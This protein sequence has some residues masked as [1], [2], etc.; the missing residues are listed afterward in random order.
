MA[1]KNLAWTC[2]GL[3]SGLISVA[4]AQQAD[5]ATLMEVIVTA[6]RVEESLQKA[7]AAITALDDQ[8][9]IDAGVSQSGDLN[10]LMPGLNIGMGGP[11]SQV[12]LRGVGNYGTNGF[13]DPA[14][15]F[16]VDGI[17]LARFS[18][19]NGI[20]FDLERI[21]VLKGPQGTLYGRN[22][23]GGAVN[24]ITRKPSREDAAGIGLEAGNY[25][26]GKING[27]LNGPLG[28]R[29]SARVAFQSTKR[30]GYLSDG[31]NDD[32]SQAV[33]LGLKFD[34]SDSTSLLLSAGLT[35]IG[36]RGQVHVP[37]NRNG[38]FDNSDP[39]IGPSVGAA[40]M[41]R[42]IAPA[43][44]TGPF[45]DWQNRGVSRADGYLDVQ[46]KSVT[47]QLDT[48]LGGNDLTIQANHMKTDNNSKS[49]GPGFMFFPDE[50]DTQMSLEARL[51]GNT[52]SVRWVGGLYGF[53][54]N[55]EFTFWVD[56]GYRFNQTGTDVDQLD[57]KTVA[58]F[59]QATYSFSDTFRVTGGIRFT[60]ESKEISG[61]IFGREALASPPNDVFLPGP[62]P[63]GFELGCPP[64]TTRVLANVVAAAI[65][66][67]ATNTD[68][69]SYIWPY[70]RDIMVG[71]N[72]FDDTSWKLGADWDLNPSSMMYA[73]VSRGFKAGGFFASGNNSDLVGNKFNPET[74]VAYAFGSKN[75]FNGDRVQLNG[76][77]F[78]FDYKD[79][80]ENYLAPSN[81][82]GGFNFVTQTADAEIYGLDLELDVALSAND[83]L[84]AKLQ[85]LHAE[86]TRARFVNASPGPGNPG[87]VS[88][89]PTTQGT[90]P[91]VW[92]NNCTGF[93][94]PRSPKLS[95]TVDYSHT[96][97]LASGAGVVAGVAAQYS[98]AYWA[99][100]DYNPLQRQQSF[101]KWD[102]DLGYHGVDDKWSLTL[103]GANLS[104]EVVFTNAFM[105]PG[106]N[107]T[108]AY[109]SF[110]QL[111]APRT[112]GVR[113]AT[114]F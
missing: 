1:R 89:C 11:S 26:L 97:R 62:P 15:A 113:F 83:K 92:Y 47:A 52:G 13:A 32:E 81:S 105:Y 111:A 95:G 63:G 103:W 2:I 61:Q 85:Y 14:V 69:D 17:Y 104:D 37:I 110:T 114:R 60:N 41:L 20:F 90:P 56:Q 33:R 99:A 67:S 93:E 25:G 64:G 19:L 30:D 3:L 91:A 43:G 31:Y 75:R 100:V 86:Y 42:L 18:G 50:H 76:E 68:G 66:Q 79:H 72:S 22:A 88:A 40:P 16:N 77:L 74:L 65:P 54:E 27:Y 96:F 53:E 36:G 112:Y 58:A 4:T 35:D 39:Y 10:K 12:Y 70:C 84:S 46:V 6:Q 28:E 8:A 71:K 49:Y 82:T 9:L 107:N 5:E 98:A 78:F 101:T 57:D 29:W 108:T 106:S 7:A 21:E 80:Q 44:P 24:L 59:A 102:A 109:T 73:S 87:P 38:Y 55:Q 94:M 48:K 23:T 45:R 51:S 34:A